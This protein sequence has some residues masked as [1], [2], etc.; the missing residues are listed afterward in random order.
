[1]WIMQAMHRVQI[2]HIMWIMFL[3]VH[4]ADYNYVA[5]RARS[6]DCVGQA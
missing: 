4:Y 2:K 6:A 5:D 3:H 1:M